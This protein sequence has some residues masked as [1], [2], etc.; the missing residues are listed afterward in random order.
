MGEWFA[1]N[2]PDGAGYSLSGSFFQVTILPVPATE[3]IN[4]T[5]S[6]KPDTP[7][8]QQTD[9]RIKTAQVQHGEEDQVHYQKD[10]GIDDIWPFQTPE[11]D[12]SVDPFIDFIGTR[13]H[14]L[15]FKILSS[16]DLTPRRAHLLE[17][18]LQSKK[19]FDDSADDNQ[20]Y[21]GAKPS[22]SR[23]ARFPVGRTPQLKNSYGADQGQYRPHGIH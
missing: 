2:R 5:D 22:C 21:T 19:R 12:G 18:S 1:G 7:D 20:E 6:Q 14:I 8:D 3:T 9:V 4:L 11:F 13:S 16:F 15:Y 23:S 17:K 10:S